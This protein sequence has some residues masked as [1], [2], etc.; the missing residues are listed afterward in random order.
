[1][2]ISVGLAL[3]AGLA[4]AGCFSA[5]VKAPENINLGGGDIYSAPP[6]ANIPHADPNSLEALRLENQQLR[7]RIAWLENNIRK[8]QE[9]SD[10]TAKKIE[11]VSAEKS[12]Y[13][14]QRD[15][16]KAAGENK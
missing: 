11:K 15:R 16:Y 14:A 8:S 2:R 7:D 4:M 13:E 9:K 5:N 10:D 12:E 3:V 1:M 6:P